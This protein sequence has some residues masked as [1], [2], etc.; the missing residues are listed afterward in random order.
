MACLHRSPAPFLPELQF[1]RNVRSAHITKYVLRQRNLSKK[2]E[3]ALHLCDHG[4]I[5]KRIA[6]EGCWHNDRKNPQRLQK[7]RGFDAIVK[8]RKICLSL[9]HPPAQIIWWIAKNI[10][11]LHPRRVAADI[12]IFQMCLWVQERCYLIGIYIQ[13]APVSV[14]LI[15]KE[16]KERSHSTRQISNQ[17]VHANLQA[18]YNKLAKVSRR[19]NLPILCFFF[20]LAVCCI[21]V[22]VAAPQSMQTASSGIRLKHVGFGYVI[23]RA[24]IIIDQV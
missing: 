21:A 10:I 20:C 6:Q 17:I 22:I 18:I 23:C 5:C 8:L 1:D 2:A 16:I 7:L 4:S 24:G 9:F 19:E 14:M 15:R 13:L 11:K 3:H 12:L